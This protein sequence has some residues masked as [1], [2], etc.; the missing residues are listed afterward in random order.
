M[1]KVVFFND[2]GRKVEHTQSVGL[3]Q[4]T[5]E[6]LGKYAALFAL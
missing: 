1:L 2:A 5:S 3:L 6:C 4:P